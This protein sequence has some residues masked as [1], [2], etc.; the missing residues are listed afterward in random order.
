MT[1][2]K[3]TGP[4]TGQTASYNDQIVHGLTSG[5]IAVDGDGDVI[6][7]N[8]AACDHLSLSA[9]E[10]RPGVPFRAVPRL[11]P[12]QALLDE[13]E[14]ARAPIS[15]REIILDPGKPSQKEIG[16]STSLLKGPRDYNGAIFLFTDMTERRRLE[17]AAEVNRQLAQ[18]GELAA[19]VVHQVRNPLTIISGRAELL[20]RDGDEAQRAKSVQS[21]LD[22][23]KNLEKSIAQFLRFS[24]PFEIA[25]RPS[26]SRAVVDRAFQ[27]CER[28]AKE[29]NVALV[30]TDRGGPT[31]LLIDEA[32]I[33][34]AIG[35]IV[36]NAIDEVSQGGRV[37][38]TLAADGPY[39]VFEVLDD[40]PGIHLEP[41]ED[42]FSP[43]FTKKHDGTGLGLSIVQRIIT[44]HGGQVSY[45]NREEGGARFRIRLPLDR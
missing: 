45:D 18:L 42:L 2:A 25:K 37:E 12:F 23:V 11:A 32:R 26:K 9:D 24:R 35:N 22:E 6:S 4:A 39:A 13:V 40:G 3:G 28:H 29:K 19:G 33:A 17:R 43:F 36:S 38:I 8:P 21:I 27:L 7:V 20:L 14:A 30:F 34:E 5:V 44:A 31:E 1:K 15:R 10:I 41:G 16:V